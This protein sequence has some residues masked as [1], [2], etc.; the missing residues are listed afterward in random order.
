MIKK[1]R[2]T[3][4]QLKLLQFHETCFISYFSPCSSLHHARPLN[5]LISLK[6]FEPNTRL[7]DD[8]F[9]FPDSAASSLFPS[10]L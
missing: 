9:H 3:L 10:F 5:K 6:F 7:F 2:I 4:E 8:R 1:K